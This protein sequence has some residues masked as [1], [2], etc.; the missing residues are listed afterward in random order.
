MRYDRF[1]VKAREAIADAQ[2][3]AG[4]QGNPE[5]RP[6]HLLL[7]LLTQD[8]GVVASLLQHIEADVSALSREA[9]KLVDDLPNVSGGA[10]ARVSNQLQA[11]FTEA[12]DIAKA[13]GDS[14]VATEV[15]FLAINRVD[16]K[17]RQLLRD[18]GLTP[19]RLQEAMQILRGGQSVSGE[20]AES[21]YESLDKYTRD[22]TQDARDGKIDPVI[23]RD[24]EIRRTLQVLSR[25][26]KNNP[27]LIGEP[28]VGKTAIV[29]GIA[30]RIAM[31]DV[32]ESL[33]DKKVLSLDLA[34]LVAGA[35]FRGEFEERLKALLTEIEST[36]GAIILFIDEL[37]TLMGAGKS[38]GSMDA[39]NML[40]PALARGELRCIGATTLDEYR[41][42][43]EKDKAMERRFQPVLVEEPSVDDTIRILRGIKEKYEVH[44]GIKILDD[45]ILAA[46]TLSDRYISDR[47]LPDKA[48]D[49]IDEA[50]SR[51]RMEIE[52]LPQPIDKI[53]R[54][55]RG[56]KVE[57]QALAR[58]TDKAAVERA[59]LMRQ[60]IAELEDEAN[61]MRAKWMSEKEAIDAIREAKEKLEEAT[62]QLEIAERQGDYEGASKIKFG[63]IPELNGVIEQKSQKLADIQGEDGGVLREMV[64][65]DDIADVVAS[66]TG[67]PVAKLN[68]GEQERLMTMEDNLH[69]RVIGQH[70]AVV[71]V[72]D[73]VRRARAALQ[74]PNRPI[75]SFIFLG[76]TGVG[77]TELARALAE[78][79]FDDEQNMLRIDMSEFMEK[80]SVA[81]LI[82]APPGY[83]GYDEGGQLTEAIKRRPYSV[84]LL[85]EIEKAHPDVFN[86][87]LQLLDDGRITDS[88]GRTIDC[89]NTVLIM[90]SNIGARKIMEAAGDREKAQTAVMEELKRTVKPEFLNR[91][92][93]V[94]VFDALT[95]ENMNHIF[96]I[97]LKRVKRLLADRFLEIEVTEG[98][99]Q[100][101]CDAGFDPA[102]GARPLKRAIQQY[103]LNP[104]S[105]AIVAGGYGPGDTVRVD[106]EGT[107]EDSQISF[108]RIPAPD[109]EEDSGEGE[110]SDGD[111]PKALPPPPA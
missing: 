35:K 104:M 16:D 23:G 52:S 103:L 4:K 39:G 18:H 44:H 56:M 110:H 22:L 109:E 74:D 106:V 20:D 100:A 31:G 88:K 58:E 76:P 19:D 50:A 26:T 38:E 81:R 73:A 96:D 77:K 7:V 71:A 105:K 78:F 90:T 83:I 111:S 65:D 57:L 25:R 5:I 92:D 24:D 87:L 94:I 89:K 86:I 40:K 11:V 82:G 33:Q 66:W 53:E 12:D 13:L 55:I 29:E 51:L 108:E 21:N 9:A 15:L 63:D 2:A 8:Q 75:G 85:D 34:A 6:Q 47:Q 48:I 91:I 84:V 28:G 107:G 27:V 32:P 54:N 70:D 1:T 36:K 72:S 41:K 102:F 45:A 99:K 60:E 67:I 80:H 68:Q 93:D 3:L 49:L 17:P 61:E 62:H 37:H 46:A 30:Q 69:G 97:Q 14:H 64:T 98:A 10:Q 42:H 43:I 59:E 101:L 95:R 79:M